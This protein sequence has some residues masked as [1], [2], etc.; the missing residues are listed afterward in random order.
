MGYL[1]EDNVVTRVLHNSASRQQSADDGISFE[2]R[3]PGF[4]LAI[5]TNGSLSESDKSK[6]FG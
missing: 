2:H 5:D 3:E 6:I 4:S 1:D